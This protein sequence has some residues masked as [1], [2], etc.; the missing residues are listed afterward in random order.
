[1]TTYKRK[2]RKEEKASMKALLN[3]IKDAKVDTLRK[4]KNLTKT[5]A[6]V[7]TILKYEVFNTTGEQL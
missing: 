2:L 3:G 6:Y 7:H 5:K 4:K 1:M